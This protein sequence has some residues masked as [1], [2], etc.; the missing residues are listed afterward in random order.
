[1]RTHKLGGYVLLITTQMTLEETNKDCPQP[2]SLNMNLD[3]TG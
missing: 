2:H 1:M 3:F